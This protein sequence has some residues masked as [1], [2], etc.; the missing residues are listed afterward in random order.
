[1][2]GLHMQ[3]TTHTEK[4]K[5]YTQ[6]LHLT[7]L[8]VNICFV[9]LLGHCTNEHTDKQDTNFITCLKNTFRNKRHMQLTCKD[10]YRLP[11]K[12]TEH[13]LFDY[14]CALVLQ[15]AHRSNGVFNDF[16]TNKLSWLIMAYHFL[17]H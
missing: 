12:V 1:M 16:P 17:H 10:T 3:N 7:I 5:T 8:Q 9:T 13:K 2:F 11:K 6:E 15:L 4:Y 14:S